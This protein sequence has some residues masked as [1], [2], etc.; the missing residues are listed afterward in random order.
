MSFA[1]PWIKVGDLAEA[2][3]DNNPAMPATE[4]AGRNPTLYFEDGRSIEHRFQSEDRLS[5]KVCSGDG[6]TENTEKKYSAAKIRSG[7][8]LVDFIK[9]LEPGTAVT[10]LVQEGNVG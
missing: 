10:L 7:I 4:L 9:Y 8:Y 5:W 3:H 6:T 2:F 1:S